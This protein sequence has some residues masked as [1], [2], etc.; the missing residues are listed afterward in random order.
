MGPAGARRSQPGLR[1][2]AA[3]GGDSR[4]SEPS[5]RESACV[6]S[7]GDLPWSLRSGSAASAAGAFDTVLISELGKPYANR[8]SL[9]L[10]IPERAAEPGRDSQPEPEPGGG[11]A[12]QRK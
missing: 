1:P 11:P 3:G 5:L 8:G 12:E 2:A 9:P 6:G 4:A 7:A 10:T